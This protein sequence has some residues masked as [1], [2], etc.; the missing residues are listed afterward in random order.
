[1][2]STLYTPNAV[3]IFGGILINLGEHWGRGVWKLAHKGA[4]NTG[5]SRG[6][7]ALQYA[8]FLSQLLCFAHKRT[9]RL[10]I[11]EHD[12]DDSLLKTFTN[13]TRCEDESEKQKQTR[14]T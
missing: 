3:K 14:Q 11:Y 5:V 7:N 10:K 2:K 4:V 13:Y 6:E 12:K 9:S 8:W 1:M